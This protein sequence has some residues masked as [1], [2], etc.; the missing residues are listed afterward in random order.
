MSIDHIS[1]SRLS[2]NQPGALEKDEDELAGEQFE[3]YLIQMLVREMRKTIP[4]GG[5]FDS[6]AM[7]IFMD[8]FDQTIAEEIAQGGG[9]GFAEALEKSMGGNV[10]NKK[11]SDML[12][13]Y[14]TTL[15]H[16]EKP[17]LRPIGGGQ[18]HRT[19]ENGIPVEGYL[20][21]K[22]GMRLS[23]ITKDKHTMHKG[24]DIGAK[25]GT[26]IHA[27]RGG[28]VRVA[29]DRG[30]YGNVVIIDHGKGLSTT[31]AHCNSLNVKTGQKVSAN[32]VI[33][34]V[35]STGNSTGPH[36]HFEVRQNGKAID[37]EKFF[38]WKFKK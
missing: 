4:K 12:Q 35:G 6:Q 36:L 33:A 18:N 34:T 17:D 38:D 29:G 1:L 20:T 3:G 16:S 19:K 9:L 25:T 31:Y 28:T 15:P 14:N 22:Y 26:P 24:I 11:F 32:D 37:P 7:N 27:V 21:S 30:G 2:M 13:K 8:L 23:P 10:D 5:I